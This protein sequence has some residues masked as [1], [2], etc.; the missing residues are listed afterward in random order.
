MQNPM[1]QWVQRH[2]T[3]FNFVLHVMFHGLILTF[4]FKFNCKILCVSLFWSLVCGFMFSSFLAYDPKL[5]HCILHLMLHWH[6]FNLLPKCRLQL[7]G[8]LSICS[9]V[10]K[11]VFQN[12]EAPH[13][14]YV[15]LT[16]I[17]CFI[18][19]ILCFIGWFSSLGVFTIIFQ[20]LCILH[21]TISCFIIWGSLLWPSF[22]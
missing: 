10:Y 6:G 5:G 12:L 17:S 7:F 18:I 19:L 20:F 4:M 2:L 3:N 13:L 21:F 11:C 1:C 22:S 15:T 9:F 16:Y 8:V 14:N